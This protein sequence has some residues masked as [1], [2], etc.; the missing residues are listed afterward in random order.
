M[1]IR[2]RSN[3]DFVSAKN[4][5]R[6]FCETKN[7][8]I[9]V[10]GQ[11]WFLDAV[12]EK[13][14]DWQVIIYAE[15]SKVLAAFPFEYV[16]S[17]RGGYIIRNPYQAKRLGI[18]IDYGNKQTNAA[19]EAFEN[20]VSQYVIDNLPNYDVFS[21]DFDARYTNWRAFF[22]N[23]FNQQ[24]RYS[25]IMPMLPSE[26]N[27]NSLLTSKRRSEIN[28]KKDE[29]EIDQTPDINMYWSFLVESYKMRGKD[30]N[31]DEE[32]IK[33]LLPTLVAHD[34]VDFLF[35]KNAGGQIVGVKV[36]FKDS[37]RMY[38]MFSTFDPRDK[39]S[40]LPVLTYTAILKAA[41]EQRVFDFEGSMKPG[42]A[43]YN[44]EFGGIQEPYF[45]ITK[46]SEKYIFYQNLRN[47]FSYLRNIVLKKHE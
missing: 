39:P 23:G 36:Y 34:A 31:A 13:E 17:K 18:W 4:I 16:K 1:E 44:R 21:I 19:R 6:S 15:G 5:Y 9:S 22:N 20:K 10:F 28:R 8:D 37:L 30:L 32:K 46:F 42:V 11:P 27:Y 45:V 29:I 38:E 2:S 43:L 41:K 7:P 24:T 47:V 12:C 14:E 26:K 25:Y 40:S 3:Y 33:K 35:S